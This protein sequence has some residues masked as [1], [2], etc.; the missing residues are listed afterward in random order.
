MYSY[1]IAKYF[2]RY[3]FAVWA[4]WNFAR[5][6]KNHDICAGNAL[7]RDNMVQSRGSGGFPQ[8][9][10]MLLGRDSWGPVLRD[11]M[12]AVA[13]TRKQPLFLSPVCVKSSTFSQLSRLKASNPGSIVEESRCLFFV[14]GKFFLV[15]SRTTTGLIIMSHE[16]PTT[17]SSQR[18]SCASSSAYVYRAA[19]LLGHGGCSA[20][21]LGVYSILFCSR[22]LF[23]FVLCEN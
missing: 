17:R 14:K 12:L 20:H 18:Y 11:T 19:A 23:F 8:Q 7:L 3:C 4:D 6:S 16:N 2:R 13:R 9:K 10:K 1:G 22:K 21:N 15:L 5:L